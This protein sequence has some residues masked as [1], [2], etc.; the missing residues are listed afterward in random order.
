MFYFFQ[1]FG[2]LNLIYFK[3]KKKRPIS[4]KLSIG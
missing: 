2:K 3:E 1:I 4:G